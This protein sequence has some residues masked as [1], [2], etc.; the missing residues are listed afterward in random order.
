MDNPNGQYV[1]FN[2]GL[3]ST[4]LATSVQY[5]FSL[6]ERDSDGKTQLHRATINKTIG[7]VRSLLSV[8]VAVD[9]KDHAGNEPLHYAVIAH[10]PE[11][12]K[13][14][15]LFGADVNARGHLGRSPLHL[16][17]SD[18]EFVHDL[19]R[20]GAIVSSQDDKGDTPLHLALS[21]GR[22]DQSIIDTLVKSG[23]DVN[24]ANHAGITP[25]HKLLDL[26]H[27]SLVDTYR[28]LAMF[29]DSGGNV[30]QPSPNNKS[31]FQ[32][33]LARSKG[34][35]LRAPNRV[36]VLK[37]FFRHGADPATKLP[38]GE[39]FVVEFL[40]R[41]LLS[42]S[43]EF[44]LAKMLCQLANPN[45]VSTNGNSILHVLSVE[46]REP[47]RCQPDIAHLMEILLGRG[48]DPNQRNQKSETPLLLMFTERINT[49]AVVLDAM[50]TLLNSGADPM[51]RNSSNTCPLYEAAQTLP[52]ALKPM[53]K[54]DLQLGEAIRLSREPISN[55]NERKF[56]DAWELALKT[57]DWGEARTLLLDHLNFLPVNIEQNIRVSAFTVLAEKHLELAK[58]MV[59]KSRAT[60]D[61]RRSHAATILRDC[62]ERSIMV[63]LTYIDYLL[64]LC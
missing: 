58:N 27:D 54:A 14:L 23:S 11:I 32:M 49:P 44:E 2:Q 24:L 40:S 12:L 38:S 33:F 45:E 21:Y 50:R 59:Y 56:W 26:Q 42:D 22:Y 13:L 43:T 41:C 61:E 62:R 4:N 51:L 9:A 1:E 17:V 29:L 7:Q 53:L 8:G 15:L 64:T 47:Y 35:H 52:D 16:A 39:P 3:P 25:F 60:N 57:E 37:H 20:Y 6:G 55:A 28:D 31:P 36:K 30:T 48:A 63:D 34:V 19:L 46:C 18:K 10:E 5:E